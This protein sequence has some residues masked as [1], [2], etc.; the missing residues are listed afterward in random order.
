MSNEILEFMGKT[1][2]GAGKILLHYLDSDIQSGI[3]SDDT[4]VTNADLR[5]NDYIVRELS[6]EYPNF[7]ILSEEQEEETIYR[8]VQQ[9]YRL[10]LPE[11]Y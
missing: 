2:V 7:G 1:A 9:E 11:Q 8:N 10:S 6:H 3:K 4:I 5:S